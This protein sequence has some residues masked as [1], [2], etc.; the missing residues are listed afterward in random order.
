[1]KHITIEYIKSL[2]RQK[3]YQLDQ[4]DYSLT[5][6]RCVWVLS[7]LQI[8]A[9]DSI[10]LCILP[11]NYIGVDIRKVDYKTPRRF[12]YCCIQC[13]DS[14]VGSTVNK[15]FNFSNHVEITPE[16]ISEF[17]KQVESAREYINQLS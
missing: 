16:N 2:L 12:L 9:M 7:N 3:G 6:N 11:D 1:M 15:Y 8:N 13:R 5:I 10:D 17:S 14:I 4:S